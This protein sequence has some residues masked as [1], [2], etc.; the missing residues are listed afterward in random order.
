MKD[1]IPVVVVGT[2]MLF[3]LT[4]LLG[5]LI[6]SKVEISRLEQKCLIEMQEKPHKE[7]TTICNERVK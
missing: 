5:S 6:G 2:I 1:N 4:L 3:V 7:A